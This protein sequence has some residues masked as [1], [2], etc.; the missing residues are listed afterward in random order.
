MSWSGPKGDDC[1][2]GARAAASPADLRA[3]SGLADKAVS[4][5]YE[6][7]LR[8]DQL[9]LWVERCEA[10]IGDVLAVLRSERAK[11]RRR[12]GGRPIGHADIGW[13]ARSAS[14][15]RRIRNCSMPRAIRRWPRMPRVRIAGAFQEIVQPLSP[16][17]GD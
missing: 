16:P 3:R 17:S 5:V 15:A 14:P 2:S 1:R 10:Q 8:K 9:A 7:V 12:T 6:R 4:L 13:P 11:W